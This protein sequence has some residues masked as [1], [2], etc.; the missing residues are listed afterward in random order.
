MPLNCLLK[1][2]E[3]YVIKISP[4][5]YYFFKKVK[6]GNPKDLRRVL[7]TTDTNSGILK[8]LFGGM[9]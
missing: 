8:A 7:Q 2:G 6:G 5:K 3:F 9:C 4:Q 1:N